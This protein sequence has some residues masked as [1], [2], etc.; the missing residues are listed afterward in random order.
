MM[1]RAKIV[2]RGIVQGVY[3]RHNTKRKADELRLRGM[4]RNLPDG[5][6]EIVCE[7]DE[8]EIER[9][10]EWCRQGPRGAFVDG[11]DVEWYEQTGAFNDFAIVY[12]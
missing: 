2:V 11:V 6:V 7:G 10:I 5:S 3:Y 12:R 4:V 1:K 9:L 8:R